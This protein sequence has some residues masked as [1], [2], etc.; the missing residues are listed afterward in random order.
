MTTMNQIINY[1]STIQLEVERDIQQFNESVSRF[2]G[3]A[4]EIVIDS[5]KSFDGAS[6][7]FKR[8]RQLKKEIEAWK[9][10]TTAPYREIVAAIN[11]RAS[12]FIEPLQE[13]ESILSFKMSDFT[14]K[15]HL[16]K[17]QIQQKIVEAQALFDVDGSIEA[18]VSPKNKMKGSGATVSIKSVKKYRVVDFAEVPREFLMINED[19]V[20]QAMKD[21]RVI[22]G[23][24]IYEEQK[25][26]TRISN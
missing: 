24:E 11:A 5:K 19:A 22:P 17:Q 23:I 12:E 4:G 1:E 10:R 25:T 6:L 16:S 13:V 18:P 3:A 26:Q 21:G 15:E 7:D 9:L 14:R 20:K 8:A 2:V